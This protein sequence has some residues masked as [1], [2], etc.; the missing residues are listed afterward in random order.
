MKI[1]IGHEEKINKALAKVQGKCRMRCLELAD[2][3]NAVER[4]EKVL[5]ELCLCKS[6]WTG[7]TVSL[8]PEKVANSYRG[9]A[10]GTAC[11]LTRGSTGW[12]L[13]WV[14]RVICSSAPHGADRTER[15]WLI[16]TAKAQ[17]PNI[18]KL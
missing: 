17:L 7:C 6:A 13:T 16:D 5:G 9:D 2:L 3:L 4:A 10:H 1:N 11:T 18:Y 15:L 14:N 12:F 8:S